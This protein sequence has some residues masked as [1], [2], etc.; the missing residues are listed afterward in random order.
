MHR[1]PFL[2]HAAFAAAALLAPAFAFAQG[3]YPSKP[4][5]LIVPNPPGGLV[6][7]S[8]RIVSDSLGKVLNQTVIVDN[9]GGGSG[10][11]AYG[12]VARAPADGYTLLTSYSAYHVGNP[13]LTPKLPWA[14]KD[15][16][17]VALVTVA[18]NV[19]AAWSNAPLDTL[20][21]GVC[22]RT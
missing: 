15:F 4:V 16:T 2:R 13:S 7:P 19:I 1:R 6:D 10:N 5:T 22:T 12:M 17:P 20:V 18:T 8:A 21:L 14:Q 11:V 3:A 9:R